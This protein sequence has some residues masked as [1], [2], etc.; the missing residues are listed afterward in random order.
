[1]IVLDGAGDQRHASLPTV[2]TACGAIVAALFDPP[3]LAK[4]TPTLATQR[5]LEASFVSLAPTCSNTSN[6]S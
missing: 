3:D 6:T 5:P 4:L 1:M 2:L